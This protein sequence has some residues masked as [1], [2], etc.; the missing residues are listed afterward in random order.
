MDICGRVDICGRMDVCGRVDVCVN[1]TSG[2]VC[3]GQHGGTGVAKAI[4]VGYIYIYV[5]HTLY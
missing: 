3:S 5:T 1:E 4:L 2:T